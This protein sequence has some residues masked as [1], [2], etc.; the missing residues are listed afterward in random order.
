MWTEKID[1]NNEAEEK[2]QQSISNI[3]ALVNQMVEVKEDDISD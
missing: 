2:K 1:V 3:E